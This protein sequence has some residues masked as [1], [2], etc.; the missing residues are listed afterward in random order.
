MSDTSNNTPMQTIDIDLLLVTALTEEAQVVEAV[1]TQVATWVNEEGPCRLYDYQAGMERTCRIATASAHQMGA[2]GMG[3]FTTPLLEKLRPRSAVLVG[4]AA[5]V[6]TT[7]V[8]LGDVPFASQVLSFDDISVANDGALTFRTQGFQVDPAMRIAVGG[9]RLSPA[10][11]G[12]WQKECL[13]VIEKVVAALNLLRRP[14]IKPPVLSE[15]PHIVVEAVA[16]GPFL[17]RDKDFRD[18]LTKGSSLPKSSG[19]RVTAPV[20]PKLVSA[21][22]ESHGFMR[23]AHEHG[24]HGHGVPATVLKGISDV[25]DA[26]KAKL[27]EKTGGFYRA[28][29]CS[30]AVLAI[31][32]ILKLRADLGTNRIPSQSGVSPHR[33]DGKIP[34]GWTLVDEAFLA[35]QRRPLNDYELNLYFDGAVPVWR[36]VLSSEIPQRDLVGQLV[37]DIEGHRKQGAGPLFELLLGAGG[38]GKSTALLQVAVALAGCPEWRVL[39]RTDP[40]QKLSTQQLDLLQN[41]GLHWLLVADDA[42]TLVHPML[43]IAKFIHRTGAANI[44]LLACARDTDWIAAG[45]PR[46]PWSFFCALQTRYLRGLGL[47][48]AERIVRSWNEHRRDGR[49]FRGSIASQAAALAAAASGDMREGSFFGGVL[50][51]RFSPE[52]L[53]AHISDLMRRLEGRPAGDKGHT[54][55]DAFMYVSSCHAIGIPGLDN[56][57]LADLLGVNPGSVRTAVEHPLGEEAGAVRAGRALLT[58]HRRVAEGALVVADRD[59]GHNLGECFGAIIQQTIET[60]RENPI[61]FYSEIVHCSSRLANN[62]PT[63]IPLAHRLETAVSAATCATKS[64]PRRLSYLMDL[65]AALAAAEDFKA[66]LELF[67]N[68]KPT[69]DAY[70][71]FSDVAAGFYQNWASSEGE[72][73]NYETNA[74]IAAYSL[75]DQADAPLSPNLANTINVAA[76]AFRNAADR[77]TGSPEAMIYGKSTRAWALLGLRGKPD[78]VREEYFK[79]YMQWADR[80]EIPAPATSADII[81]WLSEGVARVGANLQFRPQVFKEHLTFQ[82]LA[83]RLGL[84]AVGQDGSAAS[85]KVLEPGTEVPARLTADPRGRGRPWATAPDGRSGRIL[86]GGT[87]ARAALGEEVLLVIHAASGESYSFCWP[88]APQRPRRTARGARR[89]GS[90]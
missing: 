18:T 90:R 70:D 56:L 81:D 61:Q 19:I 31:L 52:G 9:L 10:T 66:R 43:E 15:P 23:A 72:H 60:G 12:P 51:A 5:A 21:E 85:T 82:E 42:D 40:E 50:Q 37:Q 32:H 87:A 54:L 14:Q 62:L 17:L 63:Q 86:D 44:H 41:S 74:W 88:D 36:H 33:H 58:R 24:V 20:H 7:Q 55:L 49:E 64:S 35:E 76:V 83:R 8:E 22:M 29:A 3:V 25:G 47:G 57:V 4:I 11:Y 39:W 77:L 38:E 71:D 28:Y 26:D 68:T 67:R 34:D 79:G 2:V 48:E 53:L 69:K 75:S 59:F 16:G 30:N 78:E 89:I 27:E 46:Q 80:K 6:D 45:G 73:G 13:R 84:P 1:L 65:A